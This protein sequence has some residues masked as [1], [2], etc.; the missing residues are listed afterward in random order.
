MKTNLLLCVCVMAHVFSLLAST[1]SYGITLWEAKT[2]QKAWS[3][4]KK[5]FFE[6]SHDAVLG[7]DEWVE[8]T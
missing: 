8:R 3:I 1:N 6:D 5:M 2:G 7:E 4:E